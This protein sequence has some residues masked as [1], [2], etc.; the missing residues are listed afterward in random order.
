MATAIN[1]AKYLAYMK[2]RWVDPQAIMLAIVEN[3]PVLGMLE[4]TEDQ[5]GG[6]FMHMPLMRVGPVGGSASYT[7]ARTNAVGSTMVGFDVTYASNYQILFFDGDAVDDA[8][9]NDN[10]IADLIDNETKAGTAQIRK[11]LQ[12]GVFGNVGGAR[13]RIG[14]VATGNA[15]ANC[16]I[17]LL[18]ITDSKFFE[19]G[20]LLAASANDGTAT[21]HALRA[22]GA[23]IAITA[24]DRMLGY[25]EFASD[26]TVTISGLVANDYLF[27]DG[28][29]KAK[30][31]GFGGWVPAAAPSASESFFGVDRSVNVN[32]LSGL[33]Y[34]ATNKPLEAALVDGA[35]YADL[36]DAHFDMFVCNPVR[37]A[38]LCN[39]LGADRANRLTKIEGSGKVTASYEAIMIATNFGTIP[40]VAD[41]G[42]SI[43]D[44]LG[45]TKNTWKIGYCGED[46]VHVV[47]DDGLSLRR[48]TSIGDG[49]AMDLKSRGNMGCKQPG[50]NMRFAL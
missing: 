19:E 2:E 26:I 32:V 47:S 41:G 5:M 6:R 46:L 22:A 17:V 16:R 27:R 15:G 28:D 50:E 1:R 3:S 9:G 39:S 33:R 13:G 36:Y 43:N 29:F 14:S 42:C 34:D 25:L 45:L 4:K 11:D 20:M 21:G 48:E 31:T 30:W 7:K 38:R 44:A 40:L 49:W 23:T 8:G 18:N 35:G 10:A 37:W 12:Q 24:I